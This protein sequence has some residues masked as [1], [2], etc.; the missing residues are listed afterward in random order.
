M[1]RHLR[2]GRDTSSFCV[3]FSLHRLDRLI[4]PAPWQ[5][6]GNLDNR[7]NSGEVL[8][9]LTGYEP[10][11]SVSF[12]KYSE[13][14]PD[15]TRHGER[16]STRTDEQ[17]HHAGRLSVRGGGEYGRGDIGPFVGRRYIPT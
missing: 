13:P 7:A 16:T 3:T 8:R 9:I 2:Q 4:E 6:T 15:S 5:C 12:S 1:P 14:D 10:L 11:R 17:Q